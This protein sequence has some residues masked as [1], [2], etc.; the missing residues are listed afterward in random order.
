MDGDLKG[1]EVIVFINKLKYQGVVL[2]ENTHDILIL[3]RFKGEIQISKNFAIIQ[4][5]RGAR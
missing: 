3:D 1:R 2:E 4:I 5:I